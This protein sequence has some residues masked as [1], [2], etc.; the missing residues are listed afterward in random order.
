MC[1]VTHYSEELLRQIRGK[2]DK[3]NE[4]KKGNPIGSGSGSAAAIQGNL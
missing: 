3:K 1:E 2:V 4:D